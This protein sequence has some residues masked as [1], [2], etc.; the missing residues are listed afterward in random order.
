MRLIR[1]SL[2][3]LCVCS[4]GVMAPPKSRAQ[5]FTTIVN[6]DVSNG[7]DPLSSLIQ[8]FDGNLYGSTAEGSPTNVCPN[9]GCGTVF[10]LA[11][12]GALTM[13]S[14]FCSQPSC[15]DGAGPETS[16]VQASNGSL[17]GT[18]YGGGDHG[19]GTV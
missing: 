10:K 17:Y 16:L 1:V 2:T 9:P 19:F 18:T 14:T 3:L 4:L 12:T 7:A 11:S 15:S 13:L 8:G 6:F 5:T